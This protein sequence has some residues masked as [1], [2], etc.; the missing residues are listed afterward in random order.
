MRL[1]VLMDAGTQALVGSSLEPE[2][3]P[4][5]SPLTPLGIDKNL[6]D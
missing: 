1:S 3:V 2:E 5:G 6:A 4:H